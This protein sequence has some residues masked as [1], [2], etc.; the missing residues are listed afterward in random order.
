MGHRLLSFP[1]KLHSLGQACPSVGVFAPWHE[2]FTLR[3][4]PGSTLGRNFL[5]VT[6]LFF[7]GFCSVLSVPAGMQPAELCI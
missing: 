2:W 6:V 1:V 4:L 3:V 7:H 5:G